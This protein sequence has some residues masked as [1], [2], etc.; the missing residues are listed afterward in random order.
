[1]A[2]PPSNQPGITADGLKRL[3]ATLSADPE[4]AGKLY[5]LLQRKLI[6]YFQWNHCLQPEA[7]AD[8]ALDRAARRLA[9][10]EQVREPVSYVLGIARRILLENKRHNWD[11]ELPIRGE[12]AQSITLGH[13]E[14]NLS[15]LDSCLEALPPESRAL[16]LEYYGPSSENRAAIRQNMADRMGLDVNAL[17]NRVLRLR[18]SLERKMEDWPCEDDGAKDGNASD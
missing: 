7:S 13:N 2:R 1:M 12:L 6:R 10:G 11:F 15:R 17:R 3:L 4:E 16:L 8:K 5:L 18:R 14:I 9:G